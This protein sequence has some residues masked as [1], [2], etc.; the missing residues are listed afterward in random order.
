MIGYLI[1]VNNEVIEP[2]SDIL[3]FFTYLLYFPKILSG[4]IER[5]QRFLPQIQKKREF[6][7]ALATDG[8]RQ[9]IYGLF[10]KM[11]IADNCTP[12]VNSIF[13][14]QD[15]NGS[16]LVLAGMLYIICVYADFSGYSDIACGI[17]KLF[18]IR[19]TN[20]FAFPFFSTNI[21]EFWRKWHISLTSWMMDY[22]F[23]PL[24]FILRRFKKLGLFISILVTFTIVGIWHGANWTF[25]IFGVLHG[26]YFLP[27]I[28]K[29]SVNKKK[30]VTDGN[31]L[32]SIN[33]ISK[34]AG[35]FL[36]VAV[37]VS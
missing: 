10:K 34:M 25:I 12:I 36:L 32:P 14:Y 11:V 29:D 23:T 31:F 22:I 17:S 1:D 37:T 20:N 33:A 4:P 21:S 35:L 2:T 16:A 27:L 30:I 9:I 6:D 26:L 18:N 24:S 8:L 3:S 7:D 19:I 13:N 5:V 15:G 28:F